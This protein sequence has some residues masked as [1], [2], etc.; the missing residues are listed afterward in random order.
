MDHVLNTTAKT[1]LDAPKQFGGIRKSKDCLSCSQPY[2]DQIDL[3]LNL[4]IG[5]RQL[6]CA[7]ASGELPVF[8]IG[9]W[10]RVCWNDVLDFIEAH[11]RPRPGERP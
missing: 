11:R 10:P 4:G 7:I 6:R 5:I 9:G 3:L 1:A 2:I 8:D